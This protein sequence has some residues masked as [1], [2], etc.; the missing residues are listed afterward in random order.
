[1]YAPADGRHMGGCASAHAQIRAH[2]NRARC[3]RS[4]AVVRTPRLRADHWGGA[5]GGATDTRMECAASGDVDLRRDA[6][7]SGGAE[8]CSAGTWPVNIRLRLEQAPTCLR[9]AGD[10]SC[11]RSCESSRH[12][13]AHRR[14]CRANQ[15]SIA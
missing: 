10:A 9:P 8:A 11:V 5:R 6:A 15:F 1:M 12:S 14:T 3:S 4:G 7:G 13:F 2:A